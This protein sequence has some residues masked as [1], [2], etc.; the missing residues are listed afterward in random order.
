MLLTCAHH[1]LGMRTVFTGTYS[2][3]ST[4]CPK[5]LPVL[6]NSESPPVPHLV[7]FLAQWNGPIPDSRVI[8]PLPWLWDGTAYE[9]KLTN[10]RSARPFGLTGSDRGPR[11]PLVTEPSSWIGL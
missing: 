5:P 10:R 4:P 1:F 7:V 8:V 2:R 11:G 6:S 9:T 3:N